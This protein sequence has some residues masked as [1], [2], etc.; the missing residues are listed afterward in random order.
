MIPVSKSHMA[1]LLIQ[2]QIWFMWVGLEANS[3]DVINGATN[4][5]IDS[6]AVGGSPVM[7]AVNANTFIY[8]TNQVDETVSVINGTNH[9][10]VATIPIGSLPIGIAVNPTESDLYR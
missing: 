1:L 6:I 2:I 7:V 8:V 10:V 3:V 5:V 9:T 4:S